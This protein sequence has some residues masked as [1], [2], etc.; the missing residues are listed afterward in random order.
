ME[1]WVG[2]PIPRR[3]TLAQC[4]IELSFENIAA[5][6][7]AG[8]IALSKLGDKE[9]ENLRQAGLSLQCKGGAGVKQVRHTEHGRAIGSRLEDFVEPRVLMQPYTGLDGRSGCRPLRCAATN[10]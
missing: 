4:H 5:P 3:L 10:G 9:I 6:T 1:L 7:G 8:A 2:K